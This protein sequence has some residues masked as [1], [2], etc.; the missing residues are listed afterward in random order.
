MTAGTGDG[1]VA[2][3]VNGDARRV[4]PGSTVA[5]LL[6]ELGTETRGVAVAVDAEVVPRGTWADHRLH[7]G[8]RVEILS[9]AR[10][11]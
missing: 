2:I 8:E 9:I 4:A 1:T 5:A 7:G 6:A 10:G 11:G 3:T